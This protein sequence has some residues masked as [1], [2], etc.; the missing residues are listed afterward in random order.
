MPSQS[1]AS[2]P[3]SHDESDL[4]DAL[5]SDND[6]TLV[7][8]RAQRLQQLSEELSRAKDLR[9][10]GHGTY[11][12]ILDEGKLMETI[13]GTKWCVVHFFKPDFARCGIMNG[14][15]EVGLQ[16]PNKMMDR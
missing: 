8:Y 16:I 1:P 15:L 13:T 14:H 5:D 11:T 6:P 9:K 2:S 7:P 4:L 10:Q 3:S 12:E